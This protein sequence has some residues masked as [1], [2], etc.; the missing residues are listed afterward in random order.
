M[1]LE[2]DF[3]SEVAPRESS[4]KDTPAFRAADCYLEVREIAFG[5]K[6]GDILDS[7]DLLGKQVSR[8]MLS[9]VVIFP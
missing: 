3:F 7:M 1:P 4:Y 6:V 2:H 9:K 8:Y 5:H